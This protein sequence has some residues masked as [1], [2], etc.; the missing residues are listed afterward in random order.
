MTRSQMTEMEKGLAIGL[1]ESMSTIEIAKK[2]KR[3]PR[4]I[5][6]FLKKYKETGVWTRSE[7]SGRP[8][9]TSPRDDRAIARAAIQNRRISSREIISSTGIPVS[10]STIRNRLHEVGLKSYWSS[11]KPWISEKNRSKRLKWAEEHLNWTLEQ[12]KQVLWSDESPF[13]LSF[14]GRR[15]V[16]RGHNERY[17]PETTTATV[18]HD[19]KINIWGCFTFAGV[20]R[21]HLVSGNMDADQY[22]QILSRQ[23]IP[24][25]EALFGG[26]EWTFQ[27]DNDPKHTATIVKTYL[28]RKNIHVL[29]WPAQ[30]PD[31]NPIENLWSILDQRSKERRPSTTQELFE[32]LK[33]EWNALPSD[34]LQRLVESM[35]RRC[36]AVIENKGF[37]TKY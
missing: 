11:K 35:P 31:L 9:K 25:S 5:Q 13:Y 17:S 30:S 12:W 29:S 24:S 3:D 32:I 10:L 8:R 1:S 37:A 6:R 20:G 2:L 18:K 15:R 21:I 36:Q 27:H 23:M 14:K 34:V 33:H 28:D 4:T 7:G 22:K 19:K 16:W 26:E